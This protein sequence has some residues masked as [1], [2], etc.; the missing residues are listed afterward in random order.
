MAKFK[1][2]FRKMKGKTKGMQEPPEDG[3]GLKP[4]PIDMKPG[5][6]AFER[7]GFHFYK[8]TYA[9]AGKKSQ[10][11]E[12]D[13]VMCLAK[14]PEGWKEGKWIGDY[15]YYLVDENGKNRIDVFE[16]NEFWDRRGQMT[17]LDAE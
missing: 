2:F 1:D 10:K 9:G 17:L 8:W 4:L 14:L 6:E 3:R 11:V 16:E 12:T 7:L 13:Q 5:R 15:H